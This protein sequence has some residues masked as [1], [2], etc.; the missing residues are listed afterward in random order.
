MFGSAFQ[1]DVFGKLKANPETARFLAQPDFVKTISEIQKDP[2]KAAMHLGDQRILGALGVLM[3][4]PI[5]TGV[6]PN[7]PM[8][9]DFSE[10]KFVSEI[11]V[12]LI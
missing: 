6:N 8:Q 12:S 5:K 9:T 10:Q 2:S 1:G 7:D 3:G 4:I 11:T